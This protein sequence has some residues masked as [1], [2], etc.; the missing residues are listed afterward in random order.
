[1]KGPAVT[2]ETKSHGKKHETNQFLGSQQSIEASQDT[3][4]FKT[5]QECS[6]ERPWPDP[7]QGKKIA[8]GV[9][10]WLEK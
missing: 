10:R 4:L 8:I 9:N 6:S 5:R 7:P 1:V 2:Q 3:I